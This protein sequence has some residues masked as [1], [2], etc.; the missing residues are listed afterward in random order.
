MNVHGAYG[1]DVLNF[2]SWLANARSS[3]LEDH[4]LFVTV[5]N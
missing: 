4:V 2:L 5:S 3:Q 1:T